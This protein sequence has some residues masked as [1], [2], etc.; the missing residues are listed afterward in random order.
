MTDQEKTPKE[1][2]IE[3][4]RSGEFMQ[5]RGGL[6]TEA[7]HYCCLGVL[8][9]VFRRTTG[10]G[11]WRANYVGRTEFAVGLSVGMNLAPGEVALWVGFEPDKTG[12]SPRANFTDNAQAALAGP[13]DRGATFLEIADV[14]EKAETLSVENLQDFTLKY[15]K[16]AARDWK[17]VPLELSG[18]SVSEG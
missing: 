14:I 4:L 10:K 15:V 16:H 2:W 18:Y 6:R 12:S 8:C 7:G 9:E 1:L 13:N 3:A 5:G 11:E 17:P